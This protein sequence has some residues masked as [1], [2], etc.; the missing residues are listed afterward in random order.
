MLRLAPPGSREATVATS[1]ADQ[2]VRQEHGAAEHGLHAAP[3]I[4]QTAILHLRSESAPVRWGSVIAM[5]FG[6]LRAIAPVEIL[7]GAERRRAPQF[8][9]VDVEFVGF[10]PGIVRETRHGSGS[11]LVPIPRKPPK[12]RIA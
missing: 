7:V 11:R 6:F 8:L 10:E 12:L 9:V 5:Q 1:K 4:F 3:H 2:Q